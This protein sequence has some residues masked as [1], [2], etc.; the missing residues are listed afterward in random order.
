MSQVHMKSQVALAHFTFVN[1]ST[2]KIL[3]KS[4]TKTFRLGLFEMIINRSIADRSAKGGTLRNFSDFLLVLVESNPPCI[5]VAI[6]YAVDSIKGQGIP[7][8]FRG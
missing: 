6:P 4:N 5:T 7:S 1:K 3:P 8:P 2:V